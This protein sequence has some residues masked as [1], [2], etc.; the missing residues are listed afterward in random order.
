MITDGYED[1]AITGHKNTLAA[2]TVRLTIYSKALGDARSALDM[3]SHNVSKVS[4]ITNLV[5]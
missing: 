1:T 4:N 3:N 2:P 5:D